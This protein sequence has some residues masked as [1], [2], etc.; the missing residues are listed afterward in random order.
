MS[1]LLHIFCLWSTLLT[2]TLMASCTASAPTEKNTTTDDTFRARAALTPIQQRNFDKAYLEGI[3]QKLKGNTDAASELFEYALEINPD[4]SE[5]L[6]ELANMQLAAVPQTNFLSHTD[7]IVMQR[8]QLMLRRA[9]EL[10]PSNPYFRNTLAEYYIRNSEYD[11]AV[12][13]YEL[14]ADEKPTEQNIT[15]LSRLYEVMQETDKAIST[16][17]RLE[18]YQGFTEETAVEQFRIYMQAGQTDLATKA[19]ERLVDENPTELRYRVMLGD[20]YM[21][22]DRKDEAIEIYR[23]VL[24]DDPHFAMAHQGLLNHYLESGQRKL[25]H[26]EFSGLMLSPDVSF[27]DK[28]SLLQN[29]AVQCVREPERIDRDSVFN[30]FCEALSTPQEDGSLAELCVAF[31]EVAEINETLSTLPYETLIAFDTTNLMAI[32]KLI[33]SYLATADFEKLASLCRQASEDN[34]DDI[35]LAFYEGASLA[36]LDL[37]DEAIAAYERGTGIITDDTDREMASDLYASLADLYH[38]RRELTKAFQAYDSSLLYNADNTSCLNNY[39]YFLCLEGR[40][41]ERALSMSKRTI[42]AEPDNPTFLDTY[43]WALYCNKQYPQA[44]IYID[45]T[46]SNLPPAELDAPSAASLYD[47]AGDIYFR[48]GQRQQAIDFWTRARNIAQDADLV[49]QLNE[50]IK[51]KR[52]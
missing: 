27:D 30:H 52:I 25:F 26:K 31:M 32:Y 18:Q 28:R 6:Y 34:P 7:S 12:P 44:L 20:V 46:I 40:D 13:L 50:K 48:N 42:D 9:Y 17:A 1:K 24:A 8:G 23:A 21:D 47:H 36:Q 2:L 11:K 45:Q 19:I 29:Y 14:M 39:A 10:E 35:I 5:V 3:C 51:N 22:I 33:Q 37:F 38:E 41:L 4:A 43:A 49:K 16:L 15:I